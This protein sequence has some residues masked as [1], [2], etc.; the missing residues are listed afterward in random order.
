MVSDRIRENLRK[1]KKL[2]ITAL[3]NRSINETLSR[4]L[5][6]SLTTFVVLLALYILGRRGDPKLHV[7][8]DV[9]CHHRDL[10]IDLHCRTAVGLPRRQARLVGR[11][12]GCTGGCQLRDEEPGPLSEEDRIAS[13]PGTAPIDAYGNGGFR[14]AEMSHR[15]SILCLPSRIQAWDVGVDSAVTLADLTSVL[16]ELRAPTFSSSAPVRNRSFQRP[17]SV[18]H[19][20]QPGWH[21]M[22]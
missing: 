13:Y 1:F 8:H 4:T 2:E 17:R 16:D 18:R 10:F 14:F 19:S 9:R 11:D 3:L 21:L 5:M 20:R 12:T 6:T 7:C 15:G 22:P